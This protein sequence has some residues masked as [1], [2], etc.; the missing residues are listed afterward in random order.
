MWTAL[1][2]IS[3]GGLIVLDGGREITM[4]ANKLSITSAETLSAVLAEHV[5]EA[6]INAN[7]E[8]LLE[9][10]PLEVTQ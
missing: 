7:R 10:M 3:S 4:E 9:N 2:Y 1:W 8:S 5:F 6:T